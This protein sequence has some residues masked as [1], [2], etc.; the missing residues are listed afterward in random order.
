M[1]PGGWGVRGRFDLRLYKLWEATQKQH[2]V[3]RSEIVLQRS[4]YA[5]IKKGDNVTL[6]KWGC[7]KLSL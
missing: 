1:Q 5:S 7:D 3:S 6:L 4:G 2:G